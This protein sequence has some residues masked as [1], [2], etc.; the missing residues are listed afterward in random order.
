MNPD[1]H[2]YIL[3]SRS[4]AIAV[5]SGFICLFI[6]LVASFQYADYVDRRSNQR[7]CG[8]ISLF[9]ESYNEVP[10][11]NPTGQR[12]SEEMYEIAGDFRCE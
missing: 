12:I 5:I 11:T 8:L 6:G 7:L 10:P 3:V 9:N 1:K 4:T 2:H